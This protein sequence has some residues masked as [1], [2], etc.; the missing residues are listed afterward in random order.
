MFVFFPTFKAGY[1][2][3]TQQRWCFFSTGDRHY[4]CQL[5]AH[6]PPH[7]QPQSIHTY[8]GQRSPHTTHNNINSAE[9]GE[10]Y[11]LQP[12]I[13]TSKVHES[14]AQKVPPQ[15]FTVTRPQ[16]A[17]FYWTTHG[18]QLRFMSHVAACTNIL[19]S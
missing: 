16:P 4:Q 13:D 10:R 2:K 3:S 12:V 14:R 9:S 6:L 1:R 7:C 17:L 11:F 8:Q 18:K 5:A 19:L 15:H